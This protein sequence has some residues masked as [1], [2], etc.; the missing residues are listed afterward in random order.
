MTLLD[1]LLVLIVVLGPIGLV[2]S[3][4]RCKLGLVKPS[5]TKHGMT[6]RDEIQWPPAWTFLVWALALAGLIAI[7][8]ADL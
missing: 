3:I 2:A 4:L 7:R 6:R 8:V 1:N 5:M